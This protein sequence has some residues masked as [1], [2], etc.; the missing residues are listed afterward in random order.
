MQDIR[1]PGLT[2]VV[3]SSKSLADY[4]HVAGEDVVAELER[5]AKPLQGARVVHI[6]ATAYGG[7]VAEML[8]T[9]VPL[10]RSVG[11]DAEW[12]VISGTDDFF[13]VT[14][15][16]HNAL[17]GMDLDLTPAM[18]AAY[19]H[20]N[21]DNA[22]YFD[23][24]YDYVIVHDPQ[25]A[26]LRMLL[27][28]ATGKWIWRCHIDLTAANPD[29]W[30][31]LR[32]FV[33]RYDASIF[34][35]PSYVKDDLKMSKIAI[36]PPAIDPLSPKNAP[37]GDDE[38]RRIAGRYG[39][40]PDRPLLVQV[41]RFDPWKDP[42]GVIDVYRTVKREFPGVQLVMV[43]SMAHDDPEGMEY[44]QRTQD[45]ADDDTAI[46]LL[47][48][49]DGV[50]NSEVNAFQRIA[51]V[52][53]QKSLREGFGLTVTEGLW[54]DKP[55]IG[56]NVGGIPL[57]IQNGV[58]GYLVNSV[59]EASDRTLQLMRNPTLAHEMGVRGHEDVRQ[60]FLSTAN[61]R[62]YLTLFNQLVGNPLTESDT[63]RALSHV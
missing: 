63:L 53:M 24:D 51:T 47:S 18:K 61:L 15:N 1:T 44:Y 48:N 37:M 11:L 25:P 12:K 43:G 27:P 60:K 30:G 31:F 52:V 34:T 40:D 21:V 62:N 35:L 32:P 33:Q 58:T 9:L 8:H 7:G 56:G 28:E 6:N 38:A 20:A 3:L 50:G 22:V 13:T 16:M 17:Q 55:V 57:Q 54:K 36:V 19:L 29:Y 23:G 10:M 46:H 5:L 39:V 26:P 4:A 2:N 45:Y 59:E 49:L 42:L 14:K 41:S